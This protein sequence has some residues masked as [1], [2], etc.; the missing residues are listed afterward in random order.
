MNTIDFE[1]L[2]Y[3]LLNPYVGSGLA[4]VIYA[5]AM[6]G[7]VIGIVS[8][9]AAIAVYAER[10]L[11]AV[12][13]CRLG[14]M[15]VGP[16]IEI[17][18]G[19]RTILPKGWYGL[20]TLISDAVKLLAK[21]DIIPRQAD[22]LLFR[23]A[24]Y[25]VFASTMAAFSIIPFGAFLAPSSIDG[26]IL[27]LLA[28]SSVGVL[29]LVMGG[30]ASNNKWSLYGAMRSVAQVVSYEVPMGLALLSVVITVGSLDMREISDAQSGWI[31]HWHVL[32]NP[33]LLI[34]F[35]AYYIS[36]L[37]ETNRAP[38][39]IPEA[40]SELVSGYHTEYSGM[41]FSMFFLAEYANMLLVSLV[42]SLFFLGGYNTGFAFLDRVFILGPVVLITKATLLVL[43][44][45]WIRWTLPRYRVDQLMKL[46]W[47][48][49]LPITLFAFLGAGVAVF[50][51]SLV[52][53]LFWRVCIVVL[54]GFF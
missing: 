47:K 32:K 30:Y 11:S 15:E 54:I 18:I 3:A 28:A 46:C 53:R 36:A 39:D 8:G 26:G 5:L 43:V 38:F 25:V 33:F 6:A 41:R 16:E 40:E 44:M 29:G 19:G 52:Y 20:G 31:W 23:L 50:Q 48:G 1:P 13:Q 27:F 14:P 21:E 24:P 2:I 42:A 51:D 7:V 22:Q 45:I 9:Y 17:K 37:A 12:I 49:L 4:I 35:V 10:K 34:A